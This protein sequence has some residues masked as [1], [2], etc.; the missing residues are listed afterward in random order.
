LSYEQSEYD[1]QI[2]RFVSNTGERE[3]DYITGHQPENDP[4]ALQTARTMPKA[5]ALAQSYTE[6][7]TLAAM[8][9]IAASRCLDGVPMKLFSHPHL[10]PLY[11]SVAIV[12][13]ANPL[14]FFSSNHVSKYAEDVYLMNE[15]FCQFKS[16]H[17]QTTPLE[18]MVHEVSMQ[19]SRFMSQDR[20]Q[21]KLGKD[22]T[23]LHGEFSNIPI[24]VEFM[25]RQAVALAH[26]LF[27]STHES[28]Q[29]ERIDEALSFFPRN[30]SVDAIDN[31]CS[32]VQSRVET[33][34]QSKGIKGSNKQEA[35]RTL[36]VSSR[37]A[38][39]RMAL[40]ILL[41][42]NEYLST[43]VFRMQNITTDNEICPI[44]EAGVEINVNL[45]AWAD[46]KKIV[47]LYFTNGS[48]FIV[49]NCNVLFFPARPRTMVRCGGCAE[50]RSPLEMACSHLCVVCHVHLCIDCSR[51][52]NNSCCSV[53]MEKPST[54]GT[55]GECS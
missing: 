50:S 49:E 3:R 16:L 43:G 53:C 40:Q 22:A 54:S 44:L 28:T 14:Y 12:I 10:F 32:C 41:D 1:G 26:E 15:L 31:I 51:K 46:T 24:G 19:T 45:E 29:K 39:A 21:R 20:V 25:R 4:L 9:D 11:A 8:I 33:E 38:M 23:R 17:K 5:I 47:N 13:A 35:A 7:L 2:E 34:R 48:M 37:D 27:S 18:L 36:R 30:A 42:V 6:H 55:P 52:I